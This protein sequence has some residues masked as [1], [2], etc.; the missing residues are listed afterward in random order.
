MRNILQNPSL[1]YKLRVSA[2]KKIKF[3]KISFK[4]SNLFPL[5]AQLNCFL[6]ISESFVKLNQLQKCCGT[7]AGRFQNGEVTIRSMYLKRKA[8]ENL[9]HRELKL[10][11]VTKIILKSYMLQLKVKRSAS[12]FECLDQEKTPNIKTHS[13]SL[14]FLD[15]FVIPKTDK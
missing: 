4:T 12:F 14:V 13:K 7:V 6:G 8:F 10:S 15:N 2:H 5:W 9:V 3:T 1:A 11:D